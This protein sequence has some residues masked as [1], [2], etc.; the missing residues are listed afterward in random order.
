MADA[1]RI[2]S[3]CTAD[4]V[5][6]DE[7]GLVNVIVAVPLMN[8]IHVPG[9]D[10]FWD[11]ISEAVVSDALLADPA[12]SVYGTEDDNVLLLINGYIYDGEDNY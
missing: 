2:Y 8:I 12:Y 9:L 4:T 10:D 1:Q 6:V 11:M 3:P 5:P 7:N